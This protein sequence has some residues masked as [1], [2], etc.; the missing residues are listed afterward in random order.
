MSEV[1]NE[2]EKETIGAYI[3]GDILFY[4]CQAKKLLF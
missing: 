2:K 4:P 1:S 3:E